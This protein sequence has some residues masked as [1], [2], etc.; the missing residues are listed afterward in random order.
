MHDR[1][2][3]WMIA[4]G[5]R[6]ESPEDRRMRPHRIAI[7]ESAPS[8]P[9]T[10]DLFRRRVAAVIAD[11]NAAPTDTRTLATDCCPA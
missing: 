10:W 7:T 11:R 5:G 6:D 1:G 2:I 9:A 4:G 8:R 3:A